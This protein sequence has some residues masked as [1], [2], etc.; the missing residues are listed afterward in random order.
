[1]AH[2]PVHENE[3]EEGLLVKIVSVNGTMR[4]EKPES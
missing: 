3:Q 1:M 2:E 4:Q